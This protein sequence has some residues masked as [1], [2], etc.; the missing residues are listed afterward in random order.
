MVFQNEPPTPPLTILFLFVFVSNPFLPPQGRSMPVN[1]MTRDR[2]ALGLKLMWGRFARGSANPCAVCRCST[3][4]PALFLDLSRSPP[5][6][7]I[8][9][10]GGGLA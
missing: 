8:S 6:C 1:S 9:S 4:A 7:W 10:R 3:T 5:F 2:V